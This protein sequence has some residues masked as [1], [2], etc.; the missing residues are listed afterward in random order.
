M[1]FMPNYSKVMNIFLLETVTILI[2][3]TAAKDT[4]SQFLPLADLGTWQMNELN[5][6]LD[7]LGLK[8][9]IPI[10]ILLGCFNIVYAKW[11]AP[12]CPKCHNRL[13]TY[14]GGAVCLKCGY[15]WGN[16]DQTL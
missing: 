15:I 12:R 3:I 6:Y 4:A 11:I 2:F 1:N 14:E 9:F 5:Y 16:D 7:A 8:H 10:I 13:H